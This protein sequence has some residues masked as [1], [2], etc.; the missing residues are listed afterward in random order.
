MGGGIAFP[1]FLESDENGR[2]FFG[3]NLSADLNVILYTEGSLKRLFVML[4]QKRS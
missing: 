3:I 2:W 4:Q 1:L